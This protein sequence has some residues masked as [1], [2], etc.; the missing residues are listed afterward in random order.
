MYLYVVGTK[1]KECVL[2][3]TEYVLVKVV[4]R[5]T[6]NTPPYAHLLLGIFGVHHGT[7]LSGLSSNRK[8]V[9]LGIS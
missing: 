1:S 2:S 8:I 7:L 5:Q 4:V 6:P 3:T 9:A